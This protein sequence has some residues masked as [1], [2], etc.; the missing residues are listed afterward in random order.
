MTINQK[1]VREKVRLKQKAAISRRIQ[2]ALAEGLMHWQFALGKCPLSP[3]I[4]DL[5]TPHRFI[6][7]YFKVPDWEQ[8]L[9]QLPQVAINDSSKLEGWLRKYKLTKL[10]F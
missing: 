10:G 6:T 4:L 7:I 1:P 8:E 2:S 3:S 5:C 9:D